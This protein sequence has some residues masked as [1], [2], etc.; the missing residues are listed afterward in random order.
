MMRKKLAA[1]AAGVLLAAANPAFAADLDGMHI[2]TSQSGNGEAII[3][4]HGW[5]CDGTFWEDQV[6]A[7][8]DD[9]QVITLDLPGHGLSDGLAEE[10]F[11]VDLFAQAVEAARI[12]AG[13]DKVVL[14]GH[15]MGAVVIR[16]Y[17]LDYPD[18]VAGL[19]AVDGSIDMRPFANGSP[20]GSA[21]M[22]LDQR[23][24]MVESMFV[25][26]T[27]ETHRQKILDA[28]LGAPEATAW[29]AQTAMFSPEVQSDTV[30]PMPTLSVI[31]GQSF[32]TADPAT[33][34]LYPDWEAI[35]IPRTGHFLMMEKPELFN[36]VLE[37]FLLTRAEY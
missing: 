35:Q 4:V 32:L 29:G 36:A 25:E 34:E 24:T 9:Y 21:K 26:G 28:M 19:V 22:T 20:F 18:H 16:E 5:T 10:D 31:A 11:S 17:A 7:F 12:E 14:V 13:A 33:R 6:A 8:S 1:M 30:I 37:D 23:R 3:F 27:N 15:S 2:Q